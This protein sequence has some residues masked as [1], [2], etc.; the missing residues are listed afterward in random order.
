[1]L[2]ML[3]KGRSTGSRKLIELT[4][5]F[6]AFILADYQNITDF[7]SQLSQI[8]NKLQDLYS[9]IIF[10]PVYFIFYFFQGL[11]FVYKVFIIIFQ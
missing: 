3:R 5:K 7:S 6:Y 1:M 2:D 10:T 4:T 9:S 11:G 8:N